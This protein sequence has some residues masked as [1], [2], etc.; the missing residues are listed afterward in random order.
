MST[1][2]SRNSGGQKVHRDVC[3]KSLASTSPSTFGGFIL[4]IRGG[5]LILNVVEDVVESGGI[6]SFSDPGLSGCA[7][8]GSAGL[9]LTLST[10]AGWELSSVVDWSAEDTRSGG[11]R[12]GKELI[13]VEGI[14]FGSAVSGVSFRMQSI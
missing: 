10:K 4:E 12:I 2:G 14:S 1:M 13:R 9:M 7:A 3:F 6:F 11:K 8:S 5:I